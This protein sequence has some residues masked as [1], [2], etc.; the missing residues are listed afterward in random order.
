MLTLLNAQ[1]QANKI[2]SY[3][4]NDDWTIP[5]EKK[6]KLGAIHRL[7]R[8]PSYLANNNK[9]LVSEAMETG[10]GSSEAVAYAIL[11]ILRLLMEHPR[12][13]QLLRNELESNRIKDVVNCPFETLQQ[14]P[15]LVRT[16]K[17]PAKLGPRLG[18]I[19]YLW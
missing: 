6:P 3:V 9:D 8:E 17:H 12:H 5:V 4:V 11:H 10:G 18:D 16:G 19:I 1:I 14:L 2:H 7:S 15:F 13:M